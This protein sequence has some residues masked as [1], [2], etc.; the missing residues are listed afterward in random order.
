VVEGSLSGSQ[1]ACFYLLL[2]TKFIIPGKSWQVLKAVLKGKI[3]QEFA[4]SLFE[5][6]TEDSFQNIPLDL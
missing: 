4:Q 3:H 1:Q 6:L 2:D 5:T